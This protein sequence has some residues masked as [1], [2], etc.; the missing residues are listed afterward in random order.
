MTP[1]KVRAVLRPTVMRVSLIEA[2]AEHLIV[3]PEHGWDRER[4]MV[5]QD[6]EAEQMRS[7]LAA[8]GIACEVR[9]GAVW[10]PVE[11]R[12]Q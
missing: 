5:D 10:V 4:G 9:D 1:Q 11:E 8:A 3:W 2:T 6:E 12:P 7:A